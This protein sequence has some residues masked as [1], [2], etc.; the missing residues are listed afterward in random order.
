[1]F[2]MLLMIIVW[3]SCWHVYRFHMQKKLRKFPLTMTILLLLEVSYCNLIKVVLWQY[4]HN[5]EML[6]GEPVQKFSQKA[7]IIITI[8]S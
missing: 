6:A 7:Y 3:C 8:H 5:F 1:M 2:S 4:M